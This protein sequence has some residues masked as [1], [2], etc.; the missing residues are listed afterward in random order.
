MTNNSKIITVR[1]TQYKLGA[2]GIEPK[3]SETMA[4]SSIA[5]SENW[6]H[7][8]G[9]VYKHFDFL[10]E[11]VEVW[12]HKTDQSWSFVEVEID[13]YNVDS[14]ETYTPDDPGVAPWIQAAREEAMVEGMK[15]G[16]EDGK[17][18]TEEKFLVSF[19]RNNGYPIEH[20]AEVL[21]KSV[22]ECENMLKE[23]DLC[24][25]CEKEKGDTN[26]KH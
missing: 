2:L 24:K 20:A 10:K 13:T 21:N 7:D 17:K 18:A 22:E 26:D 25:Q 19:V 9:F 3:R 1:L 14:D 5:K 8:N 11:G 12:G 4:F 23:I 15:A 6:L 16:I